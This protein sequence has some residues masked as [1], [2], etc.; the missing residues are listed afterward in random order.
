MAGTDG[1]PGG[2]VERPG[3]AEL[4]WYVK[5]AIVLVLLIVA[6]IVVIDVLELANAV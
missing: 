6:F 1:E 3:D 4:P 5:A 2:D